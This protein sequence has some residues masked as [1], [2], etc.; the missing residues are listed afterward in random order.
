MKLNKFLVAAAAVAVLPLSVANAVEEAPVVEKPFLKVNPDGST[1]ELPAVTAKG[2]PEVEFKGG[3][4]GTGLV[5]EKAPYAEK[6]T[7]LVNEKPEFK[8]SDLQKPAKPVK[9][10]LP[11]THAV[12]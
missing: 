10:V 2:T 11:K 6:G 12:K 9:K 8:L 5:H 1:E 4:N 3:V 7:S